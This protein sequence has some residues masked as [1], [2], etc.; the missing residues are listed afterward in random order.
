MCMKRFWILIGIMLTT[1]LLG[2]NAQADDMSFEFS[3]PTERAD[4][5]L[6]DIIP[7]E[8]KVNGFEPSQ[9]EP[10]ELMLFDRMTRKKIRIARVAVPE[11]NGEY[12]FKWD[13][14]DD[15]FERRDLLGTDVNFKLYLRSYVN[16]Q[17]VRKYSK[18]SLL[19]VL[20]EG[21]S[22]QIQIINTTVPTES[23]VP[24]EPEPSAEPEL[25]VDGKTLA[26]SYTFN[27]NAEP[28]LVD[29]LT[30][31]NDTQGDGFDSDATETADVIDSI[32]LRYPN[33]AGNLEIKQVVFAVGKATFSGLSFFIDARS[34]ATVEVFVDPID[35]SKFTNFSGSIY[36]VGIQDQGNN[37]SS[38]N[39]VGQ[40][41]GSTIN[42]LSS[43][44]ISSQQV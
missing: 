40:F 38:F 9:K 16:G 5:D 39:A 21:Y 19:H 3:Y 24:V 15:L 27:A 1:A 13:V 14:P 11:N 7:I 36:R 12:K 44:S 34:T 4:Y 43:V 17:W 2:H 33:E 22:P 6:G 30:V 41:S 25:T 10:I 42:S 18:R 31:V 23:D 8:W 32:Y 29:K 37:S 35:V 20:K 28:W 26:S